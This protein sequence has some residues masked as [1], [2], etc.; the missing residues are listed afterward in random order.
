MSLAS[1]KICAMWLTMALTG[2]RPA[3][4]APPPLG[5]GLDSTGSGARVRASR[6]RRSTPALGQV[7]LSQSDAST[8]HDA[9]RT[10]CHV[11]SIYVSPSIYLCS[12]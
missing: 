9:R 10:H 2:L 3:R 4:L 6:I 1:E 5:L 11:D 7:A 12:Q 8:K